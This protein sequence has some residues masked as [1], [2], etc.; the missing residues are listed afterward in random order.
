M[1]KLYALKCKGGYIKNSKNEE[2]KCVNFNKAS[3]FGDEGLSKADEII[4]QAKDLGLNEIRLVELH[5][6]EHDPYNI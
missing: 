3:V 1:I 4:T 2:I 6:H 5:I